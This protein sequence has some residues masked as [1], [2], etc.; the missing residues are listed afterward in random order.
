MFWGADSVALV[1]I[2][3]DMK[4]QYGVEIGIVHT[5]HQLRGEESA[6]DMRFVEQL[7]NRLDSAFLRCDTR[8]TE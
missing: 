4:E 3:N 2:L 1:L 7:A 8:S 6:E 5:D